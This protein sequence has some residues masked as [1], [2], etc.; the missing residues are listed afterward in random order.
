MNGYLPTLQTSGQL[1]RFIQRHLGQ[2]IASP[3]LL[4]PPP[5]R[6]V[7]GVEQFAR[8]H[9]IPIV[10]FERGERKDDIANAHRARFKGREG[11]VL[12]GVAQERAWSFKSSRRSTRWPK[13]GESRGRQHQAIPILDLA[14]P[15][16]PPAGAEWIQ[17]YRHWVGRE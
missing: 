14:L 12:I 1:V 11:A 6:L 16:P 9:R 15:S 17:A 7:D 13:V 4:R 3:A 2:P 8:R 10:R 5:D